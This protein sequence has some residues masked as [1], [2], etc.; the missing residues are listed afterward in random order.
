MTETD[1]DHVS[2]DDCSLCGQMW[3]SER[4]AFRASLDVIPL[5]QPVCN[6]CV[7]A[8]WRNVG[9]PVRDDPNRTLAPAP[10]AH[11]D[12]DSIDVSD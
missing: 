3:P 8:F 6:A 7:M 10:M 9:L 1:P 4:E 12:T 11:L 5:P 2:E